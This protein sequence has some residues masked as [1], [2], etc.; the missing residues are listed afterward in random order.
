MTRVEYMR[1]IRVSLIVCFAILVVSYQAM[2]SAIAEMETDKLVSERNSPDQTMNSNGR[3]VGRSIVLDR[4]PAW[5]GKP[6][7]KVGNTGEREGREDQD[8]DNVAPSAI[9]R[10]LRSAVLVYNR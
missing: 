2:K 3:I 7:Y 10:T 5:V 6:Y 9:N 1:R 8:K 4:V